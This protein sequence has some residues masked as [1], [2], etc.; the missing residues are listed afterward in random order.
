MRF[1]LAFALGVS[2]GVGSSYYVLAPEDELDCI[3]EER[4]PPW[5]D[6]EPEKPKPSAKP[7]AKKVL[8]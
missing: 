7:P 2:T 1:L 4:C 3:E 8:V 5:L 6:F